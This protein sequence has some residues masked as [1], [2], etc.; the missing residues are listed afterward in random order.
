M[1]LRLGAE[2]FCELRLVKLEHLP[3]QSAHRTSDLTIVIHDTEL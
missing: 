2:T 1:K 3:A